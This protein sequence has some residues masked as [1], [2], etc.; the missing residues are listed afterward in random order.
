MWSDG[1]VQMM[2][3]V[4]PAASAAASEACAVAPVSRATP[5]RRAAS[6]SKTPI[7][8]MPSAAALRA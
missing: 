7:D 1:G 6:G 2:A 4:A 8:V 5:A 3:V